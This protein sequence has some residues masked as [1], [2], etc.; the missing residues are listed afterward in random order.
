MINKL[1]KMQYKQLKEKSFI[2]SLVNKP[3]LNSSL[4]TIHALTLYAGLKTLMIHIIF[5]NFIQDM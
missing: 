4:S 2:F 1:I 3:N 5:G